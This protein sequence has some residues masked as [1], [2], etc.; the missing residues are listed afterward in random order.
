MQISILILLVLP[1]FSYFTVKN[2][3]VFSREKQD[4]ENKNK[5]SIVKSY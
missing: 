1:L 5:F 3:T 2:I 4:N